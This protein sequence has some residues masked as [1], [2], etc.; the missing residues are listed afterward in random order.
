MST[1]DARIGAAIRATAGEVAAPE[2]L[3]GQLAA[4]RTRLAARRRIAGALTATAATALAAV[5][6][7]S[8]SGGRPVPAPP[9]IADAAAVA[10][11]RPALPAPGRDARAP[12]F[13]RVSSGGV[14]FPDYRR[15]GMR[16]RPAGLL[17]ARRGGRD[18]V[19]VSYARGGGVRASYAIVAGP[20]LRE[21]RTGRTVVRAGTR[22]TVQHGLGTTIVSWRR[23]GRT[24]VLASREASAQALLRMAAWE[25]A[26]GAQR[27]Y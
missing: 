18:V 25:P 24:C 21:P 11:R 1:D 17:R 4:Q 8:Q 13:L 14:A 7:L 5:L 9:T 2:R 23:G 22:F 27:R 10:L 20:V 19:V 15:A 16:W 6:A 12:S 3:R 26:P